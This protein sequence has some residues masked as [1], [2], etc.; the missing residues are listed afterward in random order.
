MICQFGLIAGQCKSI[1]NQWKLL[2]TLEVKW[3]FAWVMSLINMRLMV[4]VRELGLSLGFVI[5]LFCM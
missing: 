5:L 4:M 2:H 1:A 3:Q